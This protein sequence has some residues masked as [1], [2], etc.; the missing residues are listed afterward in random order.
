ME[1]RGKNTI[2][3]GEKSPTNQIFIHQNTNFSISYNPLFI[4]YGEGGQHGEDASLPILRADSY[5]F[6]DA[7]CFSS[8]SAIVTI[9][10]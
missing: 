5:P 1:I 8:V 7:L 6:A 4:E 3:R 2:H 10:D 9:D